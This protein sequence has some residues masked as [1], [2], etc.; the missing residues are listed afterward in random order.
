MEV[1]LTATRNTTLFSGVRARSESCLPFFFSR[2]PIP[3]LQS[4]ILGAHF[5]SNNH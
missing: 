4:Y 5:W 1:V 3:L 2:R